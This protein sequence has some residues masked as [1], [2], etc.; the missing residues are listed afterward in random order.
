MRKRICVFCGSNPGSGSAYLE[1]ARSLGRTIAETGRSL[2][3]GGAKVGMMGALADAALAAGA[4]VV[5]V[6]PDGLIRREIAHTGLTAL[7]KVG[8]MH[9]RKALMAELSDGFIALPGGYGT[10]DEFC[11]ILTW[12]QLGLHEKPCG[13]LNVQ[14]Y[15]DSLLA[16]LDRGV[17][18]ELLRA[19]HRNLILT[20]IDPLRLLNRME[21]WQPVH[22]PK[23]ITRSET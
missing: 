7:H 21:A 3:Y 8:S 18:D 22:L 11:E 13:M 15:F 16:F 2:V 23:W 1:A 5:G 20:E 14:G 19:A 9:E 12:A 6:M 17:K 10:L 4:E